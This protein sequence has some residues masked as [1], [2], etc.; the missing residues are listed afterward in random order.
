MRSFQVPAT[1]GHLRLAAQLAV[2]AH[3]AG[4]AR[5]LRGEDAELL[6]HRIDDVGG[7]E[8]LAFEGASIDVETNRLGEVALGDGRDGAGH[9]RGRPHQVLDQAVDRDLHIVPGA[10]MAGN[11]DALASLAFLAD[12]LADALQFA[13]HLF[14]GG[15]NLV[16]M[17]GD[18]AGQARP[19]NGQADAEITVFHGLQP[20]QDHRKIIRRRGVRTGGGGRFLSAFLFRRGLRDGGHK[21]LLAGKNA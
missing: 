13:G 12:G 8:E 6:N 14:V 20:L 5:H 7:A 16:E 10:V 19:R 9:F 15:D 2:G 21:G 3:F 11:A 4:H 1:P 17:V 18:F